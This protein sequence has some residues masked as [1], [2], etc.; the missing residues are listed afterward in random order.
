MEF[1]WKLL[2]KW[3]RWLYFLAFVA[4]TVPAFACW[5]TVFILRGGQP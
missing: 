2:M 1:N 3:L 4:C 5:L